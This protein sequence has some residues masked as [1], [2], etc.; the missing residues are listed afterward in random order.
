MPKTRLGICSH[1]IKITKDRYHNCSKTIFDD[2]T[3]NSR[4]VKDDTKVINNTVYLDGENLKLFD[5]LAMK[6]VLEAIEV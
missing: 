4:K 3:S 2:G 6:S 1:E 5:L